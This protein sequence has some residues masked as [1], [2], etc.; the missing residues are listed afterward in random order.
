[1]NGADTKFGT[2]VR[3]G[4]VE[5]AGP[6]SKYRRGQESQ[7]QEPMQGSQLLPDANCVSNTL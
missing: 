5:E 1:M 6:D 4:Q 3:A 7:D 2:T